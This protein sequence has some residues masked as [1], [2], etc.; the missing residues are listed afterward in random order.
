MSNLGDMVV[1]IVGDNSDFNKK[2]DQSQSTFEK[3]GSAAMK[4]GGVLSLGVTAPLIAV[5]VAALKSAGEFQMYQASFETMLGSADKAS[6]MISDMQALAAATPFELGDI[7]GAGKTLLQFGVDSNNVLPMIRQLGDVAQGNAQRFQSLSLAFGKIS[8]QGKMTGENLMMM[9]DAGFNPLMEISK[10]TGESMM[11]LKEK[12][13]KGLITT[14]MVTESFKRSTSAG[15]M[16]FGGMEK[17]SKTLPGL[18]STLNDD[19]MTMGRSFAD[20]IMPAVMET[21]KG[22][23]A[24]AQNVAAL[25]GPSKIFILTLIGIAAASGPAV[26][27]ITAISTAMIFLAAN[28]VVLILAGLAATAAALMALKAAGDQAALEVTN[29]RFGK[30]SKTIGVIPSK[31]EN[32]GS[33]LALQAGNS[34][35]DLIYQVEKLAAQ[36]GVSKKQI[37]DIG[38]ASENVTGEYRTQ[39]ELLGQQ[40]AREAA[41]LTNIHNADTEKKNSMAI[42]A[43]IAAEKEKQ[44]Q[45]TKDITQAQIDARK[46]AQMTYAD[47]LRETTKLSN[48]K[49]INTTEAF[50]RNQKAVKA[51]A[52][53]LALAGYTGQA[54]N[55]VW[56]NGNKALNEMQSKL[57]GINLSAE[58]TGASFNDVSGVMKNLISG[59]LTQQLA[60]EETAAAQR[61]KKKADV[62]EEY[63][64]AVAYDIEFR[65]MIAEK[66]Q[67]EK[68][69]SDQEKT[70]RV[71]AMNDIYS[72]SMSLGSALQ[73][74][75]TSEAKNKVRI[76]NDA[77]S[78][79]VKILERN[80]DS[81]L[82]QIASVLEAKL[83][84][85]NKILTDTTLALDTEYAL[86]QEK[87]NYDGLT[88]EQYLNKKISDGIAANDMTVVNDATKELALLTLKQ[89]YDVA[90][91][92]AQKVADADAAEI[93]KVADE[94]KIKIT[95]DNETK[96]ALIEQAAS[97]RTRKILYDANMAAWNIQMAMTVAAGARAAIESFVN[98]GGFPW[99]VAAAASMAAVTVAQVAVL[100]EN[101]PQLAS[102]GIIPATPGGIPFT[103]GEGG[104][105]EAIIPLDKLDQMLNMQRGTNVKNEDLFHFVVKM[106]SKPFLDTIFRATKNK[107]VLISSGAII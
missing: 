33:A 48:A 70:Y 87:I 63:E 58:A 42:E 6:K 10:A 30:L 38:I 9:I 12:M 83:A 23:S 77:A 75:Y 106:D 82:E 56:D 39:L 59:P 13:A 71:R 11:V 91:N 3:F 90:R 54:I 79:E 52:E 97:E 4:V 47:A 44:I 100:N 86:R 72:A 107:T 94:A 1:R 24:F 14:D 53:A 19:F 49:L 36:F 102:G 15:G 80:K 43:A 40:L 98:A 37:V 89:Q 25:P 55:G 32:I 64:R 73:D 5:G 76:I 85:V 103:G 68:E 7:A 99:G 16:F 35:P 69:A 105:A 101:R 57:N 18:I 34:M 2:I 17:A 45:L 67:K 92:E 84:S 93:Q 62:D 60:I 50:E 95:Q 78:E 8:S 41:V 21:V 96:K 66:T 29:E 88:Y 31:I 28:P 22:F 26:A 61:A 20:I 46:V 27:G 81:Q 51:Y 74:L 104:K 65:R